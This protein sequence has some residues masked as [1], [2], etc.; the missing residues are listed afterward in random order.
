MKEQVVLRIESHPKYLSVV[1]AVAAL[2]AELCGL[3]CQD[4]D[5]V[6]HA[7]D[8]ACSNVIK[9]VYKGDTQRQILL[10][11]RCLKDSFEVTIEDDGTKTRPKDLKQRSLDEVR[12][13]G[14]GLHIINKAFDSISY[15]ETKQEGNRLILIRTIRRDDE[16]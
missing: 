3:C 13:G 15:D 4:V 1:R 7:V 16:G 9:H 6:R 10:G 14:L 8:E 2:T 5:D 12:V 11:F